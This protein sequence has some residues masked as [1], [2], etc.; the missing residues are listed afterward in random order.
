M[1]GEGDL[2]VG[3]VAGVQQVRTETMQDKELI[4]RPRL[5][6]IVRLL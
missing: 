6:G 2:G 3:Y 5:Q 1:P 4:Q